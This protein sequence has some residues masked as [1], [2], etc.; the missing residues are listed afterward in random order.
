MASPAIHRPRLEALLDRALGHRLTLVIAETGFGKSTLL[1]SWC[2]G[3]NATMHVVTREDRDLSRFTGTVVDALRLRVPDLPRGIAVSIDA[4][5]QSPETDGAADSRTDAAAEALGSALAQHLFR[6]VT[7]VL[8]NVDALGGSPSERFLAGL[9]RHAPPL[10]HIVLAG[11]ITPVVPLERLRERGD[12]VEI[13]G[14]DL[15]LT[16]DEVAEIV[17]AALGDDAH[18]VAAAVRDA[19]AGWPVA[20][21]LTVEALRREPPDR[22]AA[23]PALAGDVQ[24][25]SLVG[26]FLDHESPDSRRLLAVAAL[27]DEVTADL[28]LTLG[29]AAAEPLDSLARRGLFLDPGPTGPGW[30]RLHAVARDV[31]QARGEVTGSDAAR[32]RVAAAEWFAAQGHPAAALRALERTGRSDAIAPLLESSGARLLDQGYADA[33]TAA[34]DALPPHV[35]SPAIERLAGEAHQLRGRWQE[36]LA[37]YRTAAPGHTALDPGLGWRM[38]LIHYL[39]GELTTALDVCARVELGDHPTRDSALLLAWRASAEWKLGDVE[40]CGRSVTTA[41]HHAT[42]VDDARALAAV[43]T[44]LGMLAVSEGDRRANDAHYLKAV[45]YAERAGDVRQIVR[46]RC[47]RGSHLVEEGDY[48][49]ALAELDIA[50]RLADLSGF[51]AFGALALSNRGEANL[52]LGRLEEAHRDLRG[53]VEMFS[54]LESSIVAYPLVALG[55]LQH[56]G[57]ATDAA[58]ESLARALRAAEDAGDV[59]ASVIALA[60]LARVLTA[61]EPSHARKMAELAVELGPGVGFVEALLAMGWAAVRA[62]DVDTARSSAIRAEA[63]ARARRDRAGA[64]EALTLLAEVTADDREAIDLAVRAASGCEQIGDVVGVARA[65]LARAARLDPDAAAPVLERVRARMQAIGCR[66]LDARAADLETRVTTNAVDG[67]DGV[68]GAHPPV[69]IET[70]GGFRV[71]VRGTPV[72]ASAWRSMKARTLLKV[73]V[74]RRGRAVSREQLM[75]LLWPGERPGALGNRFNVVVSTVRAVLDP[76]RSEGDVILADAESVRLAVEDVTVDVEE[77][78]ADAAEGLRLARIGDDS[79]RSVL[80]RAEARFVG[81]Y[82]EEDPYDDWALALREEARTA[83]REVAAA[84]AQHARADDRFDEAVRYLLRMLEHDPYDEGAHLTL[85]AVL[86]EAGRHGEAR[87]HYRAYCARMDELG[88]E[89]E[90]F[91]AA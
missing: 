32:L 11:R 73:L 28:L 26:S 56:L 70:L 46:I 63:T 29:V 15:A 51:V 53:A 54:G 12:V 91:H 50:V 44:V 6:D 27:F 81:D 45:E 69:R 62:A 3:I 68:D 61:D 41:L 74:S 64:A 22:R 84:L 52:G 59:Q 17:A 2:T 4:G 19:T 47:N 77:F 1:R 10:L 40:A 25:T 38:A 14:S 9:I 72:P 24:V 37:C 43:H 49:E 85:I 33:V 39:R 78:L 36:A 58:R 8:D 79:A 88:V 13:H 89:A 21:R 34:V 23:D 66:L 35:R 75:D 71:V 60:G 57:G 7:L 16:E 30:Y 20:V 86:A 82:L 90:P 67:V 55:K 42:E 76:E 87:R 83:Y 18:H 65:E 48:L 80:E 31:L 5:E